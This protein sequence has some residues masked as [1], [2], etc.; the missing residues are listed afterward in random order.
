MSKGAIGELN[1]T[2]VQSDDD[3][4]TVVSTDKE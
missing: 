3:T 4:L 1:G 2:G